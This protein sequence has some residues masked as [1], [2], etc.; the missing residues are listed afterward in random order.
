[1]RRSSKEVEEFFASRVVVFD[2]A[3]GTQ[4]QN[5]N[6]TAADFGG[7]A[8]EGCNEQLNITRPALIETIHRRYFEAGADIVETNTF[9]STPL[10]LAE[11]D[12]AAQAL[13][14]SREAAVIAR[15]AADAG[16]DRFVAGSMGPT[17]KTVSV[18]GGIDFEG[19]A[20]SYAVQAEGLV[21]G[22]ADLLLVETAQDTSNI[23]A[24]IVGIERA[25]KKLGVRV[26]IMLSG[27]IEPMGTMLAGQG[28]EALCASLEHAPLLSIGLN[29][30][31]GP[32]F[33]TDHIRTLAAT[34]RAMISCMP[35][36]GL[37][38]EDGHYHESPHDLAEK[39]GRFC[40][41]GWVNIVGSCCGSTPEHTKMLAQMARS[42]KP[43]SERPIVRAALSG[44]DYLSLDDC[45]PCIV[46]ERTNVIGSKKFKELIIGEAWEEAAEL[47]RKQMR[48]GAHILD[49][50][51]ANPDR[52][53][54]QDVTR[55]L[56]ILSKIVR[57]PIMI[58]STDAE[59][60]EESLKL[61]QGKGVINSVNL[62]DGEERFEA[63]IPLVKRYGG[64]V[65]VGCID[66]EGMAVTRERK[67]AVAKRSFDLLTKKYGLPARDLIFDPLVFPC[68]TG[69][70]AYVG[71]ARETVEGVRA[72][73]AALPEC[74]TILGISN[75]SFGLPSAGR[76]VLN[77]VFL[78]QNLQAG[79]DLA[80][81]NSEKLVR[82]TQI[83]PEEGALCEALIDNRGADP[84]AAFNNFFKGRSNVKKV[85]REENLPADKRLSRAVIEGSKEGLIEDLDEVRKTQEPLDII[86][87]PLMAGM[88]EVGRL[89]ADNQL[90]VAD[91]M[92]SAEVMKA[93]VT[94]LEK[95][96]VKKAGS[97][98]GKMVLATV[99]GD[100]HD[101]GKNL[102]EIIFGNNGY[103]II[104]LGI[105]VPSADLIA[106]HAKHSPALIGLSGLLVKSAQEMVNTANDLKAKGVQTPM[107]VG[108]AALSPNFTYGRIA[109]A[110]GSLVAYAKDAMSG[111]ALANQILGPERAALEKDL[112]LK[113]TA[114]EELRKEKATATS[115]R[116]SERLV[117][118]HDF[119]PPSAPDYK[120]HVI[121]DYALDTIFSYINPT[122]LY[123]KHLGL[124]GKLD[125]LLAQGDAKAQ[126]LLHVMQDLQEEVVHQSLFR[127]R[128]VYKFF[129]ASGEGDALVLYQPDGETELSRFVFPR[130]LS[131]EGLCLS[132]FVRPKTKGVPV[133]DN[134]S[135]F[136]VTC[137][138]G[139]RTRAEMLKNDGQYL[140]SHALQALAI[141]SAEGFAEHLHERMRSMWGFA[142]G[143]DV[144]MQ[145]RFSKKYRGVRVSFGYPACP[146]LEDQELLFKL[147][148]PHRHI[149]VELT[150]G[151]M[152]DPEAS[153]SALVFHHPQGR[154]FSLRDEDL[155]GFLS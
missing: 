60:I 101:I 119:V 136:V 133:K 63:V 98:K 149:G 53:E 72:M 93:A 106:A 103:E 42:A 19:L 51:L 123:T 58:D 41:A 104:N 50:C 121:G 88:S 148:E 110:Y 84:V 16:R 57:A 144:T 52:D 29:C 69:D 95:F 76:E 33:M 151:F 131:A 26:P 130:Q 97:L 45:K 90:I 39:L 17:T 24:A 140:K 153:V 36:A 83:V 147:L 1:M 113:R 120:L 99:K 40:E 74:R 127:A 86:N 78:H 128:A 64:A 135:F 77:A 154:Y 4:I 89:F 71:S 38:D 137:G 15:R 31:T 82:V 37:P 46:G 13:E 150:E 118:T 105:K 22:G 100:V 61:L 6:L 9:G 30:A 12:L 146:R 96:M 142:D 143:K 56:K 59:V 115:A 109:P 141:E 129:P 43:R 134:V 67:V 34:S 139:V 47:G 55:F 108:G 65:V 54:L 44:V 27:T 28:V 80:I 87:G 138:Q 2:G 18:T 66:E 107:L 79:L 132:D 111:L 75:V 68:G 14:I 85:I 155:R 25:F 49:V 117:V 70:A 81:V 122:M 92:Q 7:A 23:K 91:V 152:M 114:A 124:K 10:V 8:L 116:P 11:Y 145:E 35:N 62:E 94:H 20:A 3:M 102:V 32:D 125:Q 21:D 5:L 112:A 126:E 48:S 73:K